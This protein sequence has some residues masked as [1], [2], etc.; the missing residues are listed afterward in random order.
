MITETLRDI[1]HPEK[2]IVFL[3]NRG[4]KAPDSNGIVKE[5][6]EHGNNFR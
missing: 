3:V 6:V 5:E 2:D 1:A 4:R